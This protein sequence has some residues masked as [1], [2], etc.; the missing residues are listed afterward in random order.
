MQL[1]LFEQ[2]DKIRKEY[3]FIGK[4]LFLIKQK[5]LVIGDLHLGFEFML[6]EGGS[7]LPQTQIKQTIDDLNEIFTYLK[8]R[9]IKLN[10]I[11]F[12]GDIKHFFAYKSQEKNIFLEVIKII[13][14]HI[15]QENIILLKGNHEKIDIADRKFLTH[16]IYEDI[17]FI[18]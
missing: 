9:K 10:K 6:R 5:I 14:K 16:Y 2:A 17:I 7:L 18:H 15:S 1:N 12:L 13:E 11:V 4:A 8:N 3:E